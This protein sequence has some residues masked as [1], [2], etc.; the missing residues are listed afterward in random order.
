MLL[1]VVKRNERFK[2]QKVVESMPE[3]RF[4]RTASSKEEGSYEQKWRASPLTTTLSSPRWSDDSTFQIQTLSTGYLAMRLGLTYP[5]R[6]CLL[7]ARARINS[8]IIPF[9]CDETPIIHSG[10]PP[11]EGN[12]QNSSLTCTRI[13]EGRKLTQ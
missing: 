6:N 5:Y 2:V 8:Q 10:S 13:D 12:T 1:G 3:G 4:E 9:T 11:S 7:T